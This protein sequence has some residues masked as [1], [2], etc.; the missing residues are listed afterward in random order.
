[1]AGVERADRRECSEAYRLLADGKVDAAMTVL[2]RVITRNED[3]FEI[4]V[5]VENDRLSDA[6]AIIIEREAAERKVQAAK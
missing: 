6:D 3:A 2:E 4:V 1:L 5:Y